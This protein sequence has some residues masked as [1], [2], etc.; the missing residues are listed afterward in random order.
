VRAFL[1]G[2]ADVAAGGA[3]SLPSLPSIDHASL[4][5]WLS[6]MRLLAAAYPLARAVDPGLAERLRPEALA[7]AASSLARSGTLTRIEESFAE[8]SI[9]LVLLKGAAVA[10][11]AYADPALRPMTDLDLWIPDADMSRGGATLERLGYRRL[12]GLAGRPPELQRRSGGEV[13]YASGI[14]PGGL[15][16]LHYSA[17]QGW[18]VR[19]AADA[20]AGG[21]WGRAVPVAPGR[22][23]RR[24]AVEDAIL[25]TAFHVVVNQFGQAPLRG[26]LDVAVMARRFAVDWETVAERARRWR[27]ASATGLVLLTAD[28]LFG[29][30]GAG[31]ALESLTPSRARRVVLRRFVTPESVL[32]ERDLTRSWRKHALL[33][34]LVDRPR[35]AARLIGRTLWPEAWWRE[36]RYGRPVGPAGHLW[37]LARRGEV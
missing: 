24:L 5:A 36:A 9:P 3:S 37:S 14:A 17:F 18:W 33:L 28:A 30:P 29:L 25:Q 6:R 21:V 22:H 10:H 4:A 34:A 19:R 31:A 20:D 32:G 26:L 11:A 7:A 23:A 16:E 13:V 12:P 27:L 35:D 1:A 8:A 15:V 2:V